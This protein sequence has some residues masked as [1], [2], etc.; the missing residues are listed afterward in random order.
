MDIKQTF[1]RPSD[2]A[3]VLFAA[4]F[5]YSHLF[6]F[7]A[8]PIFYEEDHLFFMQ[9]AWRMYLGESLYKDFFEFTFPGTQTLY[10]GLLYIFGTKL[11]LINAVIFFQCL[12]QTVLCLAISKKVIR[13]GWFA[14]LPPCLYLFFGLRWFGIDGSH[15]MLS[16]IFI[17]L[18]ILILLNGRTY[19]RLLGAGVLCALSSFFT[20]QRG[21][22]ACVGIA[23]FLLIEGVRKR[24]DW[25]KLLVRVTIL[26]GSFL[27]V[28]FLMILPFIVSAGAGTFFEY[29]FL[30][31][32][33][34][35]THDTA[36]NYGAYKI[37]FQQFSQQ[38]IIVSAAV[39]FY[40][41]LIP[42]IYLIGFVYLLRKDYRSEIL[43]ITSI[44]FFLALGTFGPTPGR[45][46]QVS[47][48]A[49][50]IFGWLISRIKFKTDVA[51][52]FA[53]L[54]LVV[55]GGYLALRHQVIAEK[56]YLDTPTG[57]TVFLS[58]ITM[59]RY[60]WLSEHAKPN[61]YVF[62]TYQTAVNF[63][64]QLPNPTQITFLFDTGFTPEWQ[65]TLAIENIEQRK[66]RFII[67]DANWS[68]EK[69]ERNLGDNLEPLYQYLKNNYEPVRN[70]TPYGGREM[71]LWKRE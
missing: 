67:W 68:K 18:A 7:P 22:L 19:K 70:F 57:K 33:D 58:A 37:A 36:A 45:I 64:L 27:L 56:F 71:Q 1:W 63:P 24:E 6:I 50:I 62:E 42:L 46:F 25:R 15:R 28:L 66:P 5:L 43:L 47:I 20:Q 65:V 23:L 2:L 39:S 30:F 11:W 61:E 49:L 44:G 29:T 60:K 59:E 14:Y 48:P 16:P 3:F 34:Y 9:D 52:R 41:V 55:F 35:A 10:L 17:W 13:K 51:V 38:S 26:C 53:V 32:R 31:L 12:G 8:V 21:F 54:V 4:A 69:S 40:Y